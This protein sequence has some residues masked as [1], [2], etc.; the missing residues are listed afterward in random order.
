MLVHKWYSIHPV[1]AGFDYFA[2]CV[3]SH[4]RRVEFGMM[5]DHSADLS[6]P[7]LALFVNTLRQ[8]MQNVGVGM[9]MGSLRSH[10]Y[11]I[12]RARVR[13][14]VRSA[15]PLSRLLR[16]PGMLTRRRPYS[17]AGP[18]SLWHIGKQHVEVGPY[19]PQIA[20]TSWCVGSLSPM[21]A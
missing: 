11:R 20:T 18:N 4:R 14:A 19:I 12:S 10:G 21:E 2:I 15:D 5:N 8:T 1:L 7:D 6:D 3:L 16:W 13:E 17:V 9:V